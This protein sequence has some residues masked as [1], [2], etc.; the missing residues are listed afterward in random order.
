MSALCVLAAVY[1]GGFGAYF[2]PEV[3]VSWA[4][5]R[6]CDLGTLADTRPMRAFVFVLFLC[7]SAAFA[8]FWPIALAKGNAYIWDA[9]SG[10]EAKP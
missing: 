7:L 8:L 9:F 6:D 5:S 3:P 4:R 2:V 10:R 1:A